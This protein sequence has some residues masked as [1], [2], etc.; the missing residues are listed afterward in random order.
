MHCSVKML[1]FSTKAWTPAKWLQFTSQKS[2]REK[3]SI[4]KLARLRVVRMVWLWKTEVS[5][6]RGVDMFYR[7]CDQ[8][9][10][11]FQNR[12]ICMCQRDRAVST[13]E[14]VMLS[15]PKDDP[16]QSSALYLHDN[17]IWHDWNVS[18][19][20]DRPAAEPKKQQRKY[21]EQVPSWPWPI[22][23]FLFFQLVDRL[24]PW[25]GQGQRS[26]KTCRGQ[27]C[28]TLIS[29][30]FLI[31]RYLC[32]KLNPFKNCTHARLNKLGENLWQTLLRI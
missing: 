10:S 27:C 16:L 2:S 13:G 32:L 30:D 3:S 6:L 4:W 29:G 26:C 19:W 15:I 7:I 22:V 31:A 21:N 11:Y 8:W 25:P 9:G 20:G 17:L 12:F 24:S 28:K 1:S 18:I 5:Q 23:G 14:M